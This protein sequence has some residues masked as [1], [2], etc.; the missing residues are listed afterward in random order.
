M[1]GGWLASF[2]ICFMVDRVFTTSMLQR[3]EP[4]Y[5]TTYH[6]TGT[7]GWIE[8]SKWWF[9]I[10]LVLWYIYGIIWVLRNT[11]DFISSYVPCLRRSGAESEDDAEK[12]QQRQQQMQAWNGSPC[13]GWLVV[14]KKPSSMRILV[15]EAGQQAAQG[16]DSSQAG[17]KLPKRDPASGKLNFDVGATGGRSDVVPSK[18]SEGKPLTAWSK[19]KLYASAF[20]KFFGQLQVLALTLN[21]S[22]GV[23][24]KGE[25]RFSLANYVQIFY[26]DF[27]SM[28]YLSQFVLAV[29]GLL[30]FGS[31]ILV[32]SIGCIWTGQKWFTGLARLA[33]AS[34]E[35]LRQEAVLAGARNPSFWS[36]CFA[37]KLAYKYAMFIIDVICR[38][39]YFVTDYAE[40]R[41]LKRAGLVRT[42]FGHLEYSEVHVYWVAH[43]SCCF[44]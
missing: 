11:Y 27:E 9:P 10:K 1:F 37:A 30:G 26:F 13:K 28:T 17:A 6:R 40:S 7:K 20:G 5:C 21:T 18:D 33:L 23:N 35:V 34:G 38:F 22:M 14:N 36:K 31:A 32:L 24:A 3:S 12:Q 43:G 44:E 42:E 15:L 4:S 16:A 39:N 8:K 19:A 41:Y 29:V 2:R 25:E